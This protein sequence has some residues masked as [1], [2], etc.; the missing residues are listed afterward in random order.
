MHIGNGRICAGSGEFDQFRR[1]V[2]RVLF[3]ILFQRPM[4]QGRHLLPAPVHGQ[5]MSAIGSTAK[6]V[7][8]ID[9]EFHLEGLQD[10][11]KLVEGFWS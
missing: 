2:V 4:A 5:L 3:G 10:C 6:D 11:Q 7:S 8:P 9:P 1:H